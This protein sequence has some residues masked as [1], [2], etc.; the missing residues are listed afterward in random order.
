MHI[1]RSIVYIKYL[2]EKIQHLSTIC[3]VMQIDYYFVCKKNYAIEKG[4]R[5]NKTYP[6][7]RTS[8]KF[9]EKQKVVSAYIV[10]I[11]TRIGAK[12]HRVPV[13]PPW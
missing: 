12:V 11:A 7:K 10:A 3:S 8:L 13:L 2:Q 5:L 6:S 1:I 4:E 9:T